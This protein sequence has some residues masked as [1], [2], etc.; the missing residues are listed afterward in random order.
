MTSS[1]PPTGQ[2]GVPVLEVRNISKSYGGA[3]ALEGVS[4]ALQA[5][6][7]HCLAGENGCGK[8]TLIKI[9]SGAERPD[10]GEIFIDGK[11]HP[12]MTPSQAIKE[13][14]QVIYQDFSL[15]PNLTVAENI[16]LTSVVAKRSKVF[17]AGK[18]RPAA[19][20]IVKELGLTLDLDKDVER[21]S[22]ADKQLTAI[23]RALVSEARVIIMDEPT[24]ALTHSE[25]ARLFGIVRKLQDRGVALVFVSH[26]LEEALQV[27][28][29]LTILRNGI[30]VVSGPTTGFDRRSLIKHMTGRAVN[31]TRLITSPQLEERPV[32]SVRSLS[33]SGA[34][35]D[36][37]FDLHRGEILGITGLLGSGR[38]EIAESLFGVLPA[39]SGTV[40]V[41]G[42]TVRVRSIDDAIRAGIGY[43]PEDRLTQGLFLE[44]SIAD[45]IIAGS[46]DKHRR[47]PVLLDSKKVSSSI[48][49][50]FDQLRIKAP[51]VLAPVRSLSG[52]NAQRVV[53]AKWL[54]NQPKV[55]MLNGPTVGVDVGSKEEILAVLREQ[56][57][58]GMGVLVISDDV[59]ELV[60]VCNRVLIV[61]QGS[62]IDILEGDGVNGTA[63]EELMAA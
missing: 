26:K 61:R 21:L 6:H 15:F 39:D 30:H 11:P 14:I 46:V 16:V 42:K 19:E 49:R 59:P 29:D 25:V 32:L 22:V 53:L 52:G 31:E 36:V 44:K 17:S 60:T 33:V 8:S 5:G 34:F 13:G 27:S 9:I 38:S 47:G 37:S 40:E 54:A 35:H 62:V 55:L 58:N 20:R 45:N 4:L 48:R 2:P 51:N 56:A 24:T 63:I 28:Q 3:K 10:G 23:C 7:V 57:G 18:N 41:E 12:F 1:N 50:L 43:V